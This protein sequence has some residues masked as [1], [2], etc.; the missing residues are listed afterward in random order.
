[1]TTYTSD[2]NATHLDNWSYI[3]SDNVKHTN[4]IVAPLYGLPGHAFYT[5]HFTALSSLIISVIC[6]S[7]VLIIL[8]KENRKFKNRP[9]AERLVF[10]L[11]ICDFCFSTSHL[12]DHIY[13]LVTLEYPPDGV[14]TVCGFLLGTFVMAQTVVVM[15]TALNAFLLVVKEYK[16]EIGR[17]DSHLIIVAF[18]VP[19]IYHAGLAGFGYLGPS[20][21]W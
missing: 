11:A 20:G 4:I 1:M 9:I 12:V 10:Y 3:T 21:A 6:S 8:L 17:F 18:G 19:A 16:M 13:I 15:F 5:I 7:G 2:V 14:C